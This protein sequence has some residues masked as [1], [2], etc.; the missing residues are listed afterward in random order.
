VRKIFSLI[1]DSVVYKLLVL[2]ER[3]TVM[4]EQAAQALVLKSDI[5]RECAENF[6]E[7][8][9]SA[10]TGGSNEQ[11]KQGAATGAVAGAW[12]GLVSGAIMGAKSETSDFKILKQAAGLKGAVI[13]TVVGT[14]LGAGAGGSIGATLPARRN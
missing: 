12:G 14:A 9:L 13:G 4:S 1:N 7:E 11:A 3:K 6:T 2:C 10:I 5:D 8:E